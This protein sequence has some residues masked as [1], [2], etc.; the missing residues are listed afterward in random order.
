MF[1]KAQVTD[2]DGNYSIST[3]L[4]NPKII[5]SYVGMEQ[6]EIEAGEDS[7]INVR[8]S[9]KVFKLEEIVS[10]G[11]GKVKRNVVTGAI[12]SL[13]KKSFTNSS[14]TRAESALQGRASGV[15]VL[16]NSGAP[17]ANMNIRIR[18]YGSNKSSEPIYIVNGIKVTNLSNIEPNDIES[19]EVLKDAA[20]AAIYGA[21]GANGVILVNTKKGTLSEGVLSYEFQ[22]TFQKMARRIDVLRAHDYKTYMYEAGTLPYTAISNQYDTDWQSEIF[23]LS[24]SQ[25]HYLS[26]TGGTENGSFMLS[27][28]YFNQDGIVKG[29]ND[30]YQRY[31]FMFNSDRKIYDWLTIGH[32]LT[33]SKTLLKSISENSEYY[34]VISNALLL[35]PLTPAFYDNESEY[36][37]IVKNNLEEGYNYLRN[38]DGKVYG[39]SQFVTEIRN[40][41]VMKDAFSPETERNNFLYNLFLHAKPLENIEFTSRFGGDLSNQRFHNYYPKYYYDSSVNNLSSSVV[42][43]VRETS[44]WQWENYLTYNLSKGNHNLTLMTG[45]SSSELKTKY[46]LVSAGPLSYDSDMYDDL[47]F[48]VTNA[49]DDIRGN[50]FITRKVSY[51]GRVNYDYNSTYLFQASL[52]RDGAGED[53]LPE[54]TRWGIFP[55]ISTGWIISNES[56]FNVYSFLTFLKIRSSWGQNGSLSNLGNFQYMSALE[57]T[58]SYPYYEI[59]DVVLFGTGTEP[60]NLGNY[61]L[62]W[63]TSEQI[64]FGLELR[65]LK[66]HLAFTADYYSKKTKDLLTTGTPPLI[67][68]NRST[69]VNA[70]VVEN[71]GFEFDLSY[72][73]DYRDFSYKVSANLSTLHNEVTEMNPNSPYLTGATVNLETATRFDVGH[74]I[75]YFYGYKTDGINSETGNPWYL[76][77]EGERVT[78]VGSEDK[79]YIGSGIPTKMFGVTL[80]L[81]YKNFSF[82]AFLQGATGHD[83][84]L[85]IIRTDR[86]NINKFKVYFDDRWTTANR[87]ASMPGAMTESNAWHSDLLIF[88]GDYLKLKQLQLAYSLPKDLIRKVKMSKMKV[89][90]S[91]ENVFTWTKYPGVD[92]EIGSSENVNSLGIDRGMYP[93]PRIFIF[94]SEIEF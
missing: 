42:E 92:P 24:P 60:S 52:R 88:D 64:D 55:A 41:F 13:N 46:M 3:T 35:D 30:K 85:G 10:I 47:D 8:M 33:Y 56:F 39:V 28:S 73:N 79:Q 90:F 62:K 12:S 26:F 6:V 68:G 40:P 36:P 54:N 70:G 1:E 91:V 32:N 81:A 21:E 69:T 76:N 71:K 65:M 72:Q 83:V 50:R 31:S 16:M 20:S 15:Q 23:E 18:G 63:E 11:Y 44:Y 49:S 58:S 29:D 5:F 25:K 48:L 89:Y 7:I 87:D 94:G 17:G 45:M 4:D 82:S 43:E 75:W 66:D 22:Q 2:T 74:P 67:A 77:S 78:T 53:I 80:D 59:D 51:F 57:S 14:I 86:L 27:A 61:N 38:E 84:L 34:S 9:E 93:F 19:I 37:A